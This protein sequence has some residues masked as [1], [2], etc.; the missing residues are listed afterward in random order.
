MRNML[1][2]NELITTLAQPLASPQTSMLLTSTIGLVVEPENATYAVLDDGTQQE[3]VKITAVTNN[4]AIIVRGQFGTNAKNF[5]KGVCVKP[6]VGYHFICE[7][8][9]QGGCAGT[10]VIAC[11]PVAIVGSVFPDAVIGKPWVAIASFSNSISVVS[12]AMP[13]WASAAVTNGA[14]TLSGTP[15]VG[16]VDFP[17]IIVAGGCNNSSVIVDRSVK[18]CIPV[19][20]KS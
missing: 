6:Y 3:I 15:P 5:V 19:G 9:R 10:G 13:S 1:T 16:A 20:V 14:I 12:S 8:I 7:L 4:A 11:T 17:L 2:G 18:V